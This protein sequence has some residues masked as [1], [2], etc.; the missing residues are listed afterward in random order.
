MREADAGF[1]SYFFRRI[2]NRVQPQVDESIYMRAVNHIFVIRNAVI[3]FCYI[4]NPVTRAD[5]K[6]EAPAGIKRKIHKRKNRKSLPQLFRVAEVSEKE[7]QTLFRIF[8]NA[9]PF[10]FIVCLYNKIYFSCRNM[11]FDKVCHCFAVR[12]DEAVMTGCADEKLLVEHMYR[13][14]LV[15]SR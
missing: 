10:F 6:F 3:R 12:N 15:L 11:R 2:K 9:L 7:S 1:H 4:P 14:N 13:I 5:V 8:V